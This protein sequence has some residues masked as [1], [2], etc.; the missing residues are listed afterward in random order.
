MIYGVPLA[1]ANGEVKRNG[2]D[3]G[4]HCKVEIYTENYFGYR[5]IVVREE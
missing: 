4:N 1:G 5:K 2:R 3:Y